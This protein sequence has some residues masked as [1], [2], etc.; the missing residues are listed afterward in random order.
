MKKEMTRRA[1]AIALTI[2]MIGTGIP[3]NATFAA[4]ADADNTPK[5]EAQAENK[6]ESNEKS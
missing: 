6:H 2:C 3:W 5:A 4:E 1:A